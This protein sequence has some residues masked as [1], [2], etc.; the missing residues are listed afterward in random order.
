MDKKILFIGGS[1]CSGKST[2][3]ERISKECGAFYFK[4]D[5]YLDDF[6]SLAAKK[7]LPICNKV[8]HMTADENWLRTPKEQCDEEFLFYEEISEFVFQKINDVDADVV[9]TEGAAFTPD[10]MKNKNCNYMCIVPS[11]E[12]QISHYK[13]REWVPY[14]LK[15]CTDKALAF[16]NWMQR[17]IMF[18]NRV[19]ATCEVNGI[20]CIVN[21][22]TKSE[23]EMYNTVKCILGLS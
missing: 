23:I 5:D 22:G 1:P 3:A 8:R 18:A 17:D 15:D 12:F 21:D 10:I 9:I 7:G 19:K 2:V 4:V 13:L 16:D 20:T 14:V 11:P 6:T